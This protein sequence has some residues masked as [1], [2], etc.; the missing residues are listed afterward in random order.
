MVGKI[1]SSVAGRALATAIVWR[2]VAIDT[3]TVGHGG[4]VWFVDFR[5]CT[6]FTGGGVV[7]GGAIIMDLVIAGAYRHAVCRGRT[8]SR[9]DMTGGGAA[10]AADGNN[11]RMIGFT[12]ILEQ[13]KAMAIRTINRLPFA[14]R[15]DHLT[16]QVA[17]QI[18]R[19]NQ[20]DGV[21]VGNALAD[22]VAGGAG[23]MDHIVVGID[24][25]AIAHAYLL[26][27][28]PIALGAVAHRIAMV[29][30]EVDDAGVMPMAANAVGRPGIKVWGVGRTMT[31]S[32][33]LDHAAG[34]GH[35]KAVF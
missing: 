20:A 19:V 27:V 5:N 13:M 26:V 35:L 16:N 12:V 21:I 34:I 8:A 30:I 4:D 29:H 7:A 9:V 15:G 6:Q 2:I 28:T 18:G 11:R 32:I 33:S 24:G 14:L 3:R 1:I 31:W 17:G 10:L 22:R 25:C 23:V